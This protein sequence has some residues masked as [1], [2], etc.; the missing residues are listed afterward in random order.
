MRDVFVVSD[1]ILSPI[2]STSAENFSQLEKGISGIQ[3]RK[4]PEISLK[5]FYASLLDEDYGGNDPAFTKFEK[6][7]IESIHQA[8]QEGSVEAKDPDTIFIL[9]STKGNISLLE[10]EAVSPRLTEKISLYHSAELIAGHFQFAHEPVIISHACI[11]GLLAIITGMR[12]IQ[13]G[14]FRHAV[15]AGADIITYF[16]ASGFHAFWAIS[17]E[18]C[19][20]FDAKRNGIS[21]GEGAATLILSADKKNSESKIKIEGGAVSNDANHISGPSRTGLELSFAIRKALKQSGITEKE[22]DFI[23][24]HGTATIYNDEMEAKAIKL[25]NMQSIPVNS[26]K[27]YYG[28][29]LG[30]AGLIESIVSIHSLKNNIILPTFGFKEPGT[31]EIINVCSSLQKKSLRKFLKTA[32]GFGG[33]NAAAVFSKT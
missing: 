18:P 23:S 16:I 14:Q 33:C 20:P 5:P 15:I 10:K 7:L 11:S 27:G 26:L 9:S 2:G 30:A 4:H 32:S 12:L 8:L 21:L 25:S 19:K 31:S 1:N 13:S 3:K 22:I 17:N 24:A 28:H 6:M 29:T